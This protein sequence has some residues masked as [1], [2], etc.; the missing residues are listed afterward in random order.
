VIKALISAQKVGIDLSF[1][2]ATAI[3]LA[4]RDVLEA[5]KMSVNPR[6]IQTPK[7]AAVAGDGI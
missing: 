3:D 6:V 2:R 4:G 7:V 1:D 5:V